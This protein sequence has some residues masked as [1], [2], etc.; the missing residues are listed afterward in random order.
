MCVDRTL[1]PI[2][3]VVAAG[4]ALLVPGC[5][6]QPSGGSSYLPVA[7]DTEGGSGADGV[8]VADVD[9]DGDLDAVSAWEGSDR[10]R[11]HLQTSEGNWR[12]FTIAEG[13]DVAGVE[14][15]AVGDL[16]GDGLLDV[17]AA[18]ESGQ[19][20]WVRQGDL[21]GSSVLEASAG[22]GC[23]SW[24]DVEIGDVD[25]DGLPDIVAACKEGGWVSIFYAPD[26]P[27]SGDS[28]V[29]IDVDTETRRKAS[30]VRL[31]DVDQ[32]TDLDIVSA[33]REESSDSIA[34]Y[35]NPG[36][37]GAL[38]SVWDKHAIG[39]W[40][41]TIWLDVGDV[42]RD[43]RMDVAVSSWEQASFAWFRRTADQRGP[44]P[45]YEV[46]QL[47]DTRGAGITITDLDRDGNTDLVVGT[48]GN[49]RL[50]LFRPVS[51]AT[52]SWWPTTLATPGGRL[53]LVPVVDIDADGRL[54]ILTT[55]DADDGG[56]FWY[57]PWP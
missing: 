10:V 36:R 23:G 15:V 45:R 20:T 41:D 34:W 22:V 8:V 35:E 39:Q 53:D 49:G 14:D 47:A 44:W 24:I 4:A 26:R 50:T 57:R 21:W 32:D 40:P 17:V 43:G 7:I 46:G 9:D 18:C 13:S 38:T 3:V 56:V 54:D 2:V 6:A 37:S 48:Y 16:D 55:V 31:L 12:N 42:D 29:R 51:S 25:D 27:D 30:C 33:A 1:T 19:L 11:L 5:G 52:G 28:F